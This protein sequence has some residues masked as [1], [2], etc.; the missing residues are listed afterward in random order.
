LHL[1]TEAFT[2]DTLQ[3]RFPQFDVDLARLDVEAGFLYL[4]P[5]TQ[6]L[7]EALHQRHVTIREEVEVLSIARRADTL[8]VVTSTG[9]LITKSLVVTAGLGTIGIN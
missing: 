3:P 7:L 5:V 6:T 9:E 2:R 1:K 8:R 4:P